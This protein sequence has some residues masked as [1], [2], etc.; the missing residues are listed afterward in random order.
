[1]TKKLL[2]YDFAKG[3]KMMKKS[4]WTVEKMLLVISTLAF[5]G[6]SIFA[7]NQN[8]ILEA[9]EDGLTQIETIAT[10]IQRV[11][12]V[13]LES[14]PNDPLI[15]SVDAMCKELYSAETITCF[16]ENEEILA[17]VQDICTNWG[18]LKE[19]VMRYR[20]TADRN[21]LFLASE[22]NYNAS[23]MAVVL[24]KEYN[25]EYVKKVHLSRNILI[26]I[27]IFIGVF[28]IKLFFLTNKEL[29]N[30]TF[31]STHP[32]WG[33]TVKAILIVGNVKFQSTHPL[34]GAT[35]GTME[36]FHQ[37]VISIHAPPVGCDI[38]HC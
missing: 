32:L 9:N 13:E 16:A 21:T 20:V 19:V 18:T 14:N 22:E 4:E 33:A 37:T 23:E 10:T 17:L 5:L 34:W 24:I 25:A 26:G 12:K 35:Y 36:F 15:A 29:K 2:L 38:Q 27:A 11:S 30:T 3:S 8:A 6:V 7:W 28:L 1:M 31:Q